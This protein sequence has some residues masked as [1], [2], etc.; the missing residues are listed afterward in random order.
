MYVD[1]EN[2]LMVMQ[3]GDVN[4]YFFFTEFPM[5][6]N[7]NRN[8]SAQRACFLSIVAHR[9]FTLEIKINSKQK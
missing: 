1:C 3:L 9:V 6:F 8:N 5:V 4:T 7:T 2:W